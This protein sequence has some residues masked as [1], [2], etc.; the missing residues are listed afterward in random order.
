MCPY[1]SKNRLD[2]VSELPLPLEPTI[3]EAGSHDKIETMR[4]RLE[5]GE[6]LHHPSDELR[7]HSCEGENHA[8]ESKGEI[9]TDND[10]T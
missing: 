7:L 9:Q 2:D 1:F 4:Q 5:R 6:H 8:L 3:S 10:T